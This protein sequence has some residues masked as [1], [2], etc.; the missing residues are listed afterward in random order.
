MVVSLTYLAFDAPETFQRIITLPWITDGI[1]MDESW[2]LSSLSDV[3]TGAPHAAERLASCPWFTD[4]INA[5]ESTVVT[6]IG[7]ITYEAGTGAELVGM[8]FLDSIEPSDA[9]ALG[10][11][12]FLAHE[13]PAG[14]RRVLSHSSVA[15]GVTDHETAALALLYDV[16]TT[17]PD[18]VDSLLDQSNV[19]VERRAIGLPFAGDVELAI[20]RLQPGTARS[21]ELLE[22]AVRFAEEFMGEPLPA[23][24]VLLF[25]ADAVMPDFAGHNTGFSMTVHPDFDSDDDS[26][27]AH[28]APFILAH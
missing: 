23:N 2:A 13:S 17:N 12:E 27:E 8:S 6:M 14:F 7:S 3:A 5:D 16:Q 19:Q 10:S 20:V 25:Y 1:D 28:Y 21:M 18:M 4:G 22:R 24:Y 9:F 26:D 15:D 11:L